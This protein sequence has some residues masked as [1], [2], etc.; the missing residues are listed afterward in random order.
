[1]SD[2]KTPTEL[3]EVDAEALLE[4]KLEKTR[5]SRE[6]EKEAAKEPASDES[7]PQQER[8]LT[9]EEEKDLAYSE[10]EKMGCSRS[11]V[12]RMKEKHG[13]V[14]VYPHEDNRW[15]LV[16][17][18]K[19]REMR[20]IREIAGQ[21]MERLNKEILEAGCVFPML[22]D[23]AVNDLPA[24]LPDLLTNMISRLS[25]FIPVE[26]AFSLSKEL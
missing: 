3:V 20:M 21:D 11:Y 6:A 19:V 1:M 15:F 16:R 22:S 13:T 8:S 7:K 10:L 23:E 25:A 18:L 14:I 24:G 5:K 2:E 17:P 4:K 12:A 26:L 9:A